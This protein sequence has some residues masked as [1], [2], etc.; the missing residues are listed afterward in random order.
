MPLRKLGNPVVWLAGLLVLYLTVPVV[1]FLVRAG[2]SRHLGFGTSGVFPALRTSVESATISTV[3]VAVLGVPLAW[4]LARHK[5]RISSLVT[6]MVAVP[7]G[8]PPVMAG[9]LLVYLVGPY[10]WLG[11]LFDGRLTGSVAGIVLSQVFVAAPFLVI[12]ARSTFSAVDPSLDDLAATLGAGPARRFFRVWI[13]AAQGGIRAGLLLAWLRA[14]GEYGANVVIAY[15]PFSLPVYTYVQFSG[16]GIPDTQAP[17]L[18]VLAAGAVAVGV[19]SLRRP[20][21]HRQAALPAAMAPGRSRPC[22]VSFEITTQVGDFSLS[23]AHHARSHRLAILGPSGSGKSLSLRSIAGLLGP[24]A[25]QV[26]YAGVDVSDRP[27]EARRVGYVTQS[28]ALLPGRTVWEQ[29][30][31]ATDSDPGLAAWWLE[32]LGVAELADRMPDQLSGGQRQRI[33]LVQA[34]CR[35]PRLVLLDEPFSAL[36]APVRLELRRQLRRLQREGG[37]STVLVT[38]DPEEAAL[39]ADELLVIDQGRLL[40]AGSVEDVFHRPA[41]PLVARLLG[42]ANLHEGIVCS[43]GRLASGDAVIEAAE[44]TLAEGTQVM[45]CV[46]PEDIALRPSGRYAA[47]VVDLQPDGPCPTLWARLPGGPELQVRLAAQ[48]SERLGLCPGSYL[49]LDFDPDSVRLWP[50]QLDPANSGVGQ[51]ESLCF[52]KGTAGVEP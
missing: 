39:L 34:L 52:G 18:L 42:L 36:D 28:L 4:M 30:T 12:S 33:C 29:M 48:G 27:T 10:S 1:G 32:R 50:S 17:T 5:G 13:P 21:R 24:A 19:A 44:A 47:V 38:H 31:F 22:L 43:Q 51:S 26:R 15:H 11:K 25:C 40:Q 2:E 41:S 8:L 49:R 14:I 6:A 16:L 45:W 37:L 46:R 23:L 3:I 20:R 9:I 35:S 7:L